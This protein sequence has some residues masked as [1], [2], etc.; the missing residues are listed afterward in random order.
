M[1]DIT[2]YRHRV[3]LEALRAQTLE[4]MHT[5]LELL[6]GSLQDVVQVRAFL[7]QRYRPAGQDPVQSKN[8]CSLARVVFQESA[9]PLMTLD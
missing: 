3:T 7:P 8:S 2:A 9:E 4:N 6:G 1:V 5:A